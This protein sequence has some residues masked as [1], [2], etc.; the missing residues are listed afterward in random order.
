M[1]LRINKYLSECGISSRRKAEEYITQGR[2][3]LNGSPVTSLSVKIDTEK[4]H[5]TLDG[6]KLK[7]QR[8]VYLIMNKPRA[9]IT[10]T[11]DE[12]GRRTVL[13][14]ININVR[15]VPI[16]RLDYDTTGVLL[17]T[18]D[19]DFA[20]MLMHPKNKVPREYLAVIDKPLEAKDREKLGKNIIIDGK[21]GRF[22]KVSFPYNNVFTKVKVIATEGRNHFVKKMF[23]ALGYDVKALTRLT[24]AGLKTGRLQPGDY[25]ELTF[26][27]VETLKRH[28]QPRKKKSATKKKKEIIRKREE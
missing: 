13:D 15:I 3:M 25:R 21:P 12:K 16:G 1:E 17:L 18:N 4:D 27:E 5:L 19:G 22:E 23:S 9:V 14:Y 10:S 26:A 6:E 20:N 7:P 2:V 24:F 28:F 8:K 11:S